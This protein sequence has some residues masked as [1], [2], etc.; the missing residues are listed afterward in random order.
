M[1]EI[2]NEANAFNQNQAEPD[3]VDIDILV[4][5]IG[6]AGVVSGCLVTALASAGLAVRVENGVARIGG[7]SVTVTGDDLILQDAGSEPRFDLIIAQ[8]DGS[9][10][11]VEGSADVEPVF[12]VLPA[13]AVALAA[14]YIPAG[15]TETLDDYIVDKRVAVE[16]IPERI[17]A[18]AMLDF[19]GTVA[20]IGF[21]LCDGS[22]VSRATYAALFA[23]IGTTW[24]AG[25]GTTTFGVPDFRRRVAVGSGGSGTGTLGNAVGNT[26][27]AETHTLT[28]AELAA[29][30]HT[31][32]TGNESA[33]HTHSGT[34]GTQS[35]NHTHTVTA[36]SG[37]TAGAGAGTFAGTLIGENTTVTTSSNSASHT[38]TVTT[39]NQSANHTHS[40]TSANAGS[41]SAHNNLPPS[42]IVL[43]IIKT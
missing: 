36:R 16:V 28:T 31:G 18:G 13:D 24:G 27:G 43:K 11:V 14:V 6:G 5:G 19:G 1:F 37:L 34:T 9:V 4:A 33:N 35:A 12:P 15:V 7:V 2:P 39:G 38:H 29:H 8:D 10:D 23:A 40:F 25:N 42:A 26:G 41:G 3:R 22:N 21:L 32:T 20:P 17:P 30:A